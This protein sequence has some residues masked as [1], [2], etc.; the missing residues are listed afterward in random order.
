MFETVNVFIGIFLPIVLH[1]VLCFVPFWGHFKITKRTYIYIA[2]ILGFMIGETLIISL[3]DLRVS[4][5]SQIFI[6]ATLLISFLFLYFTVKQPLSKLLYIFA[7][8]ASY[9]LFVSNIASY[10]EARFFP[11]NFIRYSYFTHNIIHVSLLCLT[12]P[13]IWRFFRVHVKPVMY[14][15]NINVWKNMWIIPVIIVAIISVYTGTYDADNISSNQFL[16][17]I[18]LLGISS[19]MVYYV[20]IKMVVK[21]ETGIVLAAEKAALDN[22]SKIKSAFIAD[23]SHEIKSP[24][25][26]MSGYAE[27]AELRIDEGTANEETKENLRVISEEAH[28][29][30]QLVERLLKISESSDDA[31]I[32]LPI[33]VGDIISRAVAVLTPVLAANRNRLDV[34]VDENCP[35]VAANADMLLQVLFNLGG[36]A[37]RHCRDSIIDLKVEKNEGFVTFTITDKGVGIPAHVLSRIFERGISGDNSSGLG[38]PICKEAVEAY[39]GSMRIESKQGKGTVA[40]FT[41]PIYENPEESRT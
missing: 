15:S 7:V 36:N 19:F 31:A 25:G 12:A 6:F 37:N 13:F 9:A 2:L 29:L 8:V 20:V 17:I 11:E 41:L 4:S 34:N 18:I 38:L 1:M 14:S 22:L 30:A 5:T 24:L 40:M 26:I 33:S 27:L 23:I 10:F 3:N 21:T 16:I 28:R 35:P 39:G 32:P